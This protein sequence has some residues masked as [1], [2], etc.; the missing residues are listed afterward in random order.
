M[1][2][3]VISKVIQ[4]IGD[5]PKR[6]ELQNTP[7]RVI[8]RYKKLFAGYKVDLE[9]LIRYKGIKNTSKLE[10][11]VTIDDIEFIS[12]CEHHLLPIIGVVH[13]AYVPSKK[14]IGIGHAIKI[15]HTFTKRLQIQ[16]RMTTQI[17]KALEACLKPLG[18]AVRVHAK[19]Y[20]V[21]AEETGRIFTVMKTSCLLG[22]FKTNKQLLS[23][24]I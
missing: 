5:D 7:K 14:L 3:F 6:R 9:E 12:F 15:V 24:L 11:V 22:A 23:A 4:L 10:T 2:E 16:E 17:A 18:V 13:L 1:S 8:A 21:D 19:H 20:C